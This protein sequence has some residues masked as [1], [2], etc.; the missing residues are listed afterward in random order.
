[1]YSILL[2]VLSFLLAIIILVTF[3]EY[4]HY[5]IARL[6]NIKVLKFSI[7][8]GP[9]LFKRKNKHGTEFSLAP[10]P[11]GGYVKMLDKRECEVGPGETEYE[12]TAQHP[13]KK[14]CVVLAG[15]LFNIILA[16]I[17]FYFM[18][19][20]GIYIERPVIQAIEQDSLAAK[21]GMIV[22]DEIVKV[23][24]AVVKSFSD[25]Q[26]ALAGR[27][28]TGGSV[29]IETRPY[30][31][32]PPESNLNLTDG[33]IDTKKYT[34]NI[35]DWYVDL[36]NEP[37]S[38]SFGIWLMPKDGLP[39][40]VENIKMS[41]A[42]L[43]KLRVG[44][45]ITKYNNK[46]I[47]DWDDFLGYIKENPN[48]RITLEVQRADVSELLNIKIGEKDNKGFLGIEFRY[49]IYKTKS[50]FGVIESVFRSI[51]RTY[52]YTVQTFYMIYKLFVGQ[53]GVETVR[54]PIMVAK[55]A[56]MQ[57]QIGLSNF[58]D[59]LAI[60]SIGLAVIN[61]LPIPVL[62]GGHLVYHLYELLTGKSL[63]ARAEQISIVVGLMFLLAL[64]SI[65][66]YNDIIYW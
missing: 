23:D 32:S 58:L 59:F 17:L 26:V 21:A 40:L 5:K 51:E 3:H 44:D 50:S 7:G 11:L 9:A 35:D 8:F 14:I 31:Y 54:G 25:L 16:A 34:I 63:P 38:R 6:F 57:M 60:I 36:N 43:S 33:F 49:P 61:L 46:L 15:P 42:Y 53:M 62:D 37:A 12:F 65:A 10:I 45:V 24:N 48:K 19:L 55:V 41:N 30:T 4:G 1:M 56:G 20:N 18:F 2:T 64:M 28:G 39:L 47:T 66:F 22:G 29:N 27:I 52:N 13:I